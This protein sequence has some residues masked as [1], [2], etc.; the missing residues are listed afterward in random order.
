MSAMLIDLMPGVRAY[1]RLC[2]DIMGGKVA[3]EAGPHLVSL[4]AFARESNPYYSSLLK[5]GA[6]F[7]DL[8]PLTKAII[9]EQF[10][11]LKSAGGGATRL[12]SSG[13]STGKPQTFLQD[14]EYSRWNKATETYY[15]QSF[16]GV[17]PLETRKVVLWGSHRDALREKDLKGRAI[18][19][20]SNTVFLNSYK[21]GERD[22]EAQI[23]AVNRTK[24]HFI[25]GYAGSLHQ[26]ARFAKRRNLRVHVPRFVY[27][28]AEMLQDRMR[29]EIEEV[30]NARVYDFYGSREV[31]PIAGECRAGRKHIFTFNNLVEVVEGRILVT[32]LHNH[33][34]PLIRYDIGDMGSLGSGPCSCGSSLPWLERIEGRVTDHFLKKDRTMVY[35]GYFRTLFFYR[36]WVSQFQVSQYRYDEV[37]ISVVKD[38]TAE[39]KPE[40]MGEIEAK[41]RSALGEECKISWKFVSSIPVTPQGKH[42]PTRCL[43]TE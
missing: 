12:N 29:E 6:A 36:Q 13:G 3:L 2:G 19:W 35:A 28:S 38:E 1:R 27:S 8:P 14:L 34:M 30:F 32:N 24:P 23:E 18:S 7:T 22:L 31:G 5:D 15:Y 11:R 39:S 4:L 21:G 42:L 10:E 9:R 26:L 41:I 16:L 33:A 40:E 37:E 17:D 25:K 20:L 43:I